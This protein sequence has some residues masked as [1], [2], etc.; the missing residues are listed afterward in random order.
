MNLFSDVK[1]ALATKNTARIKKGIGGG[2]GMPQ[3]LEHIKLPLPPPPIL[4]VNK[5][6]EIS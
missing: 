2:G 1:D 4:M 5:S 6:A 3:C